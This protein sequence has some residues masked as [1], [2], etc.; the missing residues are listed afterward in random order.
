MFKPKENLEKKDL[1]KLKISC[2]I[3]L[4][5]F[6]FW[7]LSGIILYIMILT[8]GTSEV[9]KAISKKFTIVYNWSF[10]SLNIITVPIMIYFY[11]ISFYLKKKTWFKIISL[12]LT[13]YIISQILMEVLDTISAVKY[14]YVILALTFIVWV[15]FLFYLYYFWEKYKE[16]KKHLNL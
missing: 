14:N 4:G 1:H 12:S 3:L 2:F 13:V 6:T 5:I 7:V 11:F 10:V 16:S 8:I 9:S 15:S